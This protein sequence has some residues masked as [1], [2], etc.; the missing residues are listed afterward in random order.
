[1]KLLTILSLT[2]AASAWTFTFSG[3]VRDGKGNKGCTGI[4]HSKGQTFEWDRAFLSDCCIHLYDDNHCG[5][6]VGFSCSDWKKTSSR[7]LYSFKVTNC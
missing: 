2:T 4:T 3:G 7:D 5:N 6:E 1:M